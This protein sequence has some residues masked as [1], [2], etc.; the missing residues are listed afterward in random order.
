MTVGHLLKKTLIVTHRYAGIPLSLMVI[1]WFVSGIVMMYAGGMPELSANARLDKLPPLDLAAVAL[2]PAE[3][4]ERLGGRDVTSPTLTTVLERPA[5][6]FARGFGGAA[7][8]FADTGERM[9]ELSV[10]GARGVAARFAGVPEDRVAFVGTVE[11]IDQWTI[12]QSNALP[13]HRFDVDDGSGARV[14]VSPRSGRVELVTTTRTRA[15]AWVGTIPHW[16]YFTPLRTKPI[17]A[18]V[19]VWTSAA[20][21][22]LAVIGLVIGVWQ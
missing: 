7:T 5:Y 17:W 6:R 11:D 18:K 22:V 19:V 8:I 21:C 14:Y 15:L 10:D 4:A 3:A 12:T 20:V 16:L 13:L 2:T 1:V 9:Q